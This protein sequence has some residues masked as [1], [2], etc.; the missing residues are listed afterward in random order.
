MEDAK[1]ILNIPVDKIVMGSRQRKEL[2]DLVGLKLSIERKGLIH[3]IVVEPKGDQFVLIAGGRRLHAFVELGRDTIP[4][5]FKE[6][7]SDL[8]KEELELEENITRKELTYIEQADAIRKIDKIKREKYGS[9][10]RGLFG[11]AG[12]TQRDTAKAIGVSESKVSQ[13]I[14]LSEMA[15]LYPE[16]QTQPTRQDAIKLMRKLESGAAPIKDETELIRQLKATFALAHSSLAALQQL[17]STSVE[18]LILDLTDKPY[19]EYLEECYRILTFTGTAFIFYNLSSHDSLVKS[20]EG[21]SLNFDTTPYMWHIKTRDDFMPFVWASKGLQRPHRSLSRHNS[22]SPDKDA[23]HT[24]AKPYSLY[25]TLFSPV[26][27][28]DDICVDPTSYGLG[29]AKYGVDHKRKV[30]S[31]CEIKSV[32]DQCMFFL[33]HK[34]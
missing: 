12:W 3:P 34:R 24:Q 32:Y 1:E 14:R 22:H 7:L 16:L 23:V 5:T 20:F 8:E 25:Y 19:K 15:K 29:L 11:R 13:D 30:L 17:D 2:G 6:K 33:E 26:T 18:A 27:K 10:L 9:A 31:Y 21:I 28:V 4:A